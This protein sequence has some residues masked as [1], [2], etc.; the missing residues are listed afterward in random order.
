MIVLIIDFVSVEVFRREVA[1]EY[2]VAQGFQSNL[3]ELVARSGAVAKIVL[4]IL[5][6]FSVASWAII[7]RKWLTLSRVDRLSRDF[8]E[9]F[10]RSPRLSE[11]EAAAERYRDSPL[12]SIFVAGYRELNRNLVKAEAHGYGNPH[13]EVRMVVRSTEP[14]R[15]AVQRS[16]AAE[17]TVLERGMSWLATTGSVTPFIGLFGTVIGII[18]AFQG[19]GLERTTTIQAVAPG[20]AEALVATAAGLFAAIPAVIGYNYFLSRLR[21][22]AAEMDDFSSEFLS[23]V[24]RN[25]S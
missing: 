13:A 2:L 23:L 6:I 1:L 5:L 25:F 4:L 7:L 12:A 10:R 3:W 20:I 11:I 19:L 9:I 17:L 14:L 24:E 16:A 21:M 8:A 18:N 15:R 22:L